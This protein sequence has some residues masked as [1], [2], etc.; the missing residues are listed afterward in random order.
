VSTLTGLLISTFLVAVLSMTIPAIYA[1]FISVPV[2]F[3]WNY[4]AALLWV[5]NANGDPKG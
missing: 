2:V 3:A 1:K 4:P 5:F